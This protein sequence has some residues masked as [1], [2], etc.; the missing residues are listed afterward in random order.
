MLE[1]DH[2]TAGVDEWWNSR[3]G[4]PELIVGAILLKVV[5]PFERSWSAKSLAATCYVVT[6]DGCCSGLPSLTT[7]PSFS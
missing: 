3:Y 5:D 4:S 1:S 7:Q 2:S 6:A